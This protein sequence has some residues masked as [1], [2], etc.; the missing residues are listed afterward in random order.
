MAKPAFAFTICK[1]AEPGK[2]AVKRI[3]PTRTIQ[4][5]K[6]SWWRF[7]PAIENSLEA[8]AERLR[9][10]A[11]KPRRMIVMGAPLPGLDL[12]HPHRRLWAEPRRATLDAPV[13][14]WL[15][16]DLDDVVVPKGIRPRRAAH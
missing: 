7:E 1:T 4:Y 2:I 14:S 10:L 8:M 13:R 6:V 11:L 16:I 5:D 15:P 3:T 9:A 12:S